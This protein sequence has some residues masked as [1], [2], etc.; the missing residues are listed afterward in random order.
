M[1][2]LISD[3]LGI[4]TLQLIVY[5]ALAAAVIAG[6]TTFVIHERRI[7]AANLANT[8]NTQNQEA[9][10]AAQKARN[11]AARRIDADPARGLCDAWSRDCP[12]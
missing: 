6:F 11:D 7:G 12:R 5:A 1:L 10:D 9:G 8:I 3:A 2:K 4:S